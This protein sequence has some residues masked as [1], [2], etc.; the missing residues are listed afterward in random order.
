V[1]REYSGETPMGMKFSTLAGMVGGGL[2]TPGFIGI[3]K[4][5]MSSRKFISSD[6]GHRRIVW[7]PTELKNQLREELMHIGEQIG[8]PDFIDMI[9]DET[10]GVDDASIRAHMEKVGHPALD[11]WDVTQPSPEALAWDAEHGAADIVAAENGPSN[12]GTPAGCRQEEEPVAQSGKPKAESTAAAQASFMPGAD[13]DGLGYVIGVLEKMRG[14]N[15]PAAPDANA[16][17]EQQMAALQVSTALNLLTAGANM[18]LMYSHAAE[19]GKPKAESPERAES[20]ERRVESAEGAESG[21]PKA[22]SAEAR[23]APPVRTVEPV[24]S[25]PVASARVVMPSSFSVPGETISTEIRTVTLGGSG[26][27]TAAVEIGGA[28]ALPFRHF[29]GY[30]GK[31]QVVAMEVFDLV[32][33]NYPDSLRD[34]YGDLLKDSAAMAKYCV[35]E[36]G[37]EVISV[38]LDGTHPDLGDRSPEDAAKTVESV[39]KAVGAPIIVTGPGNYSKMNDVM[40]QIASAFAG[41]NLLLNWAETDNY[42]TLTAAAMGYGHC[43]VAQ[44]PIDVNMAKQLNIL[45]TSMGLAAEKIVI[46][47]MTGALGYGLEYTYS[48]MERIRTSAFTGDAMLASPM[49]SMPGYEVAKTKESKAPEDQFPLWGSE[50]DR[51]AMLEIATAMSLLNA[52]ADML[53]MYHPVAA[54]TVKRKIAE[55][56][57]D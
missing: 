45:M 26:T 11:M 35:E 40:K 37:A 9:A 57:R 21:K 49:I 5:Y 53:V 55:M 17:P 13:A 44:T 2:Q 42:K 3:G 46:D 10:I 15:L 56:N 14:T 18:L 41:E 51:G 16:T 27:R 22:E 34:A 54:K 28:A 39:L 8:I 43:V 38:R 33:K 20:G 31:P 29:E 50:V 23:I 7:M 48:V 19:S 47:A 25:R 32:P 6:G 36:I 12:G 30:T 24:V 4:A 1:N 52:G